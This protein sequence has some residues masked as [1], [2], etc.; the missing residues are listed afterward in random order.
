MTKLKE[1]VFHKIPQ[2]QLSKIHPHFLTEEIYQK[3]ESKFQNV[4]TQELSIATIESLRFLYLCAQAEG[5]LFFPGNQLIDDIW[6]LFVTETEFY[7]S[8]CKK[9]GSTGIIHH[10]GIKYKDYLKTQSYQ[11]T[12][13]EQLSWLASYVLNFGEI[14][15]DSYEQLNLAQALA[16]RFEVDLKGLN[17][18]ANT[19]IQANLE[20]QSQK[21]K[22][23]D[24]IQD[25]A[26]HFIELDR[27]RK[28]LK[29]AF[30]RV[31]SSDWSTKQLGPEHLE[32]LFYVS[33]CLAFTIWQHSA[34]L[35]RLHEN[36]VWIEKNKSLYEE[37]KSA[38]KT[39]GLG[40]THIVKETSP[41]NGEKT[42]SGYTVNGTIPWITGVGL[43]DLFV[44]GF[45]SSTSQRSTN[46]VA[47]VT[48]EDL[49][50][51][52]QSQDQLELSVYSASMTYSLELN[53][54][55]I[56][57]DQVLSET[58]VGEPTRKTASAIKIPELGIAMRCLDECRKKSLSSEAQLALV[59]IA[60]EISNLKE[61]SKDTSVDL[62]ELCFRRDEAIRDALRL[63]TLVSKGSSINKNSI[64]S[65]L[66]Q[67]SLLVDI[68]VQSGALLNRKTKSLG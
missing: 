3:L 25:I 41:L 53:N 26:P 57:Q 67:Q 27:S 34:A 45:R 48:S 49:H 21:E 66:V 28:H 24:V 68:F 62:V 37:L 35:E 64:V 1:Q 11:D 65:L 39:L 13:E 4:S 8:L 16:L 30:T 46:V 55:V 2:S 17:D 15:K 50:K 9:F 63:L 36:T 29:S 47:I 38:T 19:L 5:S 18:I 33:P 32:K 23:S 7:Q 6:H 60:A 52:I 31:M 58:L 56:S 61:K 20:L 40:I 54:L 14:Q 51:A 22:F 59:R 42:E 43:F 12:H 10:T 44:I